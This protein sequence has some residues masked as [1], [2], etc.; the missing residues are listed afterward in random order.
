MNDRKYTMTKFD[1]VFYRQSTKRD[2]HTG[3]YAWRTSSIPA[4]WR[5]KELWRNCLLGIALN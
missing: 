5:F 4:G 2:P 1:G 3:E